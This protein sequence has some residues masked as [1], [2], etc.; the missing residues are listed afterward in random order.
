MKA[1]HLCDLSSQEMI[2]LVDQLSAIIDD[3]LVKKP[4]LSLNALAK[5]CC[6]S[7]STLRRLRK[8]QVKT[9]PKIE[10]VLDILTTVYSERNIQKIIETIDDPLESY[11][12][13]LFNVINQQKAS[14][15]YDASISKELKDTVAYLIYKL[16]ANRTGVKKETV[17]EMFGNWGLQKLALLESKSLVYRMVGRYHARTKS[18][19]LSDDLFIQNFQATAGF[20]RV[21]LSTTKGR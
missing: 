19:S 9:L 12:S 16:A 11:L 6:V 18:F 10:T 20:I 5:K 13:R 8:R 14:Y 21:E 4:H 1:S 7:E 17:S 15:D 3:Y 2:V